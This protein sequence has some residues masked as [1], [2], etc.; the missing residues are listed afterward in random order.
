M[1]QLSALSLAPVRQGQNHFQAIESMVKLAQEVEKIGYRRFWIAEH[2]NMPSLASSATQL[3]ILRT[4]ENTRSIRVGS[5]GVMLPNHSPLL[6]AEQYG[7]LAVLYPDRV[8]LGLGRAPGTDQM[9]AAA[10]RRQQPH[11]SH[12]FPNDIQE[13]QR[14]FGAPEQQG[15]VR[16]FPG[17]G[18]GVPLYI[19]GSSTESAYL[20]AELGLPYAFAAHFAPRMLEAALEI[21]RR[22]FKPSEVLDRPYVIVALNAALADTDEEARHLFTTTEQFALNVVRG[23]RFPVLPPVGSMDGLWTPDEEAYVRQF[24]SCS[25]VGSPESAAA[26]MAALQTRLRADEWMV[27]GYIFD[28]AAQYRSYRM[29]KEV[30]DAV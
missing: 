1:P 8:D 28:E 9:T 25:V 16:A 2:H 7:T 12:E 6:V 20:A 19:L 27:T 17:E 18:L 26:Q 15:Y 14:Y 29:L 24:T 13:L 23:T 11:V 3:L 21:Y 4:L 5:G 30:I 10:L 22:E